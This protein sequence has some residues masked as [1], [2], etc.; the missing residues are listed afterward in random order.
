[1]NTKTSRMIE[2]YA[3]VNGVSFSRAASELGRKRRQRCRPVDTRTRAEVEAERFER[4]KA[5]RQDIY[6]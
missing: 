2:R 4:M 6:G 1:M 5:Q 3:R